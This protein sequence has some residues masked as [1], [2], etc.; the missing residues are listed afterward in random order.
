MAGKVKISI[1]KVLKALTTLVMATTCIIAIISSARIENNQP[2]SGKIVTIKSDKRYNFLEEKQVLKEAIYD[3]NIDIDN[4]FIANLDVNEME[5]T[6]KNDPWIG[7]AQVYIDNKKKLHLD[8]TQRKPIVRIFDVAGN[9]YYMDKTLATMPLSEKFH[10]YTNVVVNVP[11]I[12]NDTPGLIVKTSIA[13]LVNTLLADSFW[14]AQVS[15]INYEQGNNFSINTVFGKQVIVLGDTGRLEE[16]LANVRMFYNKVMNR[17]GWDKYDTIDVRFKEQVVASPKIIIP[18]IEAKAKKEEENS[19][20][21]ALEKT[22]LLED[23][24][25]AARAAKADN[26]VKKIADKLAESRDKR[27]AEKRKKEQEEEHKQARGH[28]QPRGHETPKI[29]IGPTAGSAP[30]GHETPK[31]HEK[32]KDGGTKQNQTSAPKKEN[33][34]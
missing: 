25:E 14:A 7:E 12:G 16:K 19:F 9:S 23:S 18:S 17:I 2:V 3:R 6:L 27:E 10:Y 29:H 33:K 13:R 1:P 22:R 15:H 26:H 21:L 24:L 5:K 4:V 31:S 34:K 11:V 32:P 30:K 28:D 8:V 20:V